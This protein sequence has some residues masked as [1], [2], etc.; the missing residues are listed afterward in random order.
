MD[1]EWRW[2]NENGE[3]HYEV[4]DGSRVVSCDREELTE[5]IRELLSIAK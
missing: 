5:T 3:G 1:V 2:R 4:T